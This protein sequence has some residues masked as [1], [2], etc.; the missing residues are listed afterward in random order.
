MKTVITLLVIL[1]LFLQYKLWFEHDSFH[2][3]EQLRQAISK[4]K[5]QND[6]LVK[7]NHEL[8]AEVKNLKHGKQAVESRARSELG[9]V[10]KGETFYQIVDK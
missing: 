3:T 6:A 4:Q 10:Q 1:F 2:E 7:K 5:Q 8:M 9:M